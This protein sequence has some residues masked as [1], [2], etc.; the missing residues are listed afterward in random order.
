MIPVNDVHGKFYNNLA[1]RH[2]MSKH[3]TCVINYYEFCLLWKNA[4][5]SKTRNFTDDDK[6]MNYVTG[7]WLMQST[8]TGTC[9][10]ISLPNSYNLD[11]QVYPKFQMAQYKN[12]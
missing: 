12:N 2:V 1:A 3:L 9:T 11:Y 8:S 5:K 7:V 4:L 10:S 6:Y